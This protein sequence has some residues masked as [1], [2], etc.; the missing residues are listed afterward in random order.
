MLVLFQYYLPGSIECVLPESTK[1]SSYPSFVSLT[2]SNPCQNPFNALKLRRPPG[3]HEEKKR[4]HSVVCVSPRTYNFD[5]SERLIEF[6]E[7]QRVLKVDKVVFYIYDV[8]AS[9]MRVLK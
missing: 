1:M 2:F 6:I 5:I 8:L 7:F 3:D 4:N 9:T